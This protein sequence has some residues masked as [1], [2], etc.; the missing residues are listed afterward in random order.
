MIRKAI[1]CL[2]SEKDDETY[3]I[4]SDHF[5]NASDQVICILSKIISCMLK[6]GS[7]SQ[8]MNKSIIKP[9]PKNKQNHLQNQVTV[10]QF[11]K[12]VL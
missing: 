12:I 11:R 1:G 3:G 2:S 6:H 5:I 10:G 4:T 9:I 8:Q 7:S